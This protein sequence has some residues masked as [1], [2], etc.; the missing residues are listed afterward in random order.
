MVEGTKSYNFEPPF[1]LIRRKLPVTCP[2]VWYIYMNTENER[3]T[4]LYLKLADVAERLQQLTNKTEQRMQWADNLRD[5]ETE[6]AKELAAWVGAQQDAAD[7][8]RT[9]R[10]SEPSVP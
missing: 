9:S 3:D 7:A 6:M 1:K 4:Q 5:I 10:S 8:S 2:G